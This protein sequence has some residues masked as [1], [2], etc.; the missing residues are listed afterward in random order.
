MTD[1]NGN[2]EINFKEFFEWT[3][4]NQR[5]ITATNH[6]ADELYNCILFFLD[7]SEV[8]KIY[9]DDPV[10]LLFAINKMRANP[11]LVEFRVAMRQGWAKAYAN[12]RF[13]QEFLNALG[14]A[15]VIMDREAA[16]EAARKQ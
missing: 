12:D 2:E 4:K 10:A 7:Q 13:K 8:K 3:A 14:K 1:E 9:G 11:G 5:Y 16:A 6:R 15:K